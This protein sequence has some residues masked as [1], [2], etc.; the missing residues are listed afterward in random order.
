VTTNPIQ[1]TGDGYALALLAGSSLMD[2]EQVQF[3]P[4]SIIH[5]QNAAGF[6]LSCYPVSKLFNVNQERFMAKYNAENLENVTRDQ[7]S[8]AIANEICEGRGTPNGGV[9]LDARDQWDY[10]QKWFH[11]EADF[12]LKMGIDLRSDLPEIAPAAHFSMGGA[13]TAPNGM[14]EIGQLYMVGETAGGLHGANRLGNNALPECIVFG[15]R[16]GKLAAE[17]AIHTREYNDVSWTELQG[18]IV[19]Y[20]KAIL[21]SGKYRPYK[22][23]EQIRRLMTEN[24]GV[25]RSGRGLEKA[26]K[27]L[28]NM[29][30]TLSELSVAKP[31]YSLS[32]DVL[33]FFEVEKPSV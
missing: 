2:M 18:V 28:S 8:Y 14:S 13:V 24:S 30:N 12:C 19:K 1:S 16:S 7:L 3:Y 29:L 33:D 22:F 17:F 27:E 21:S 26:E 20:Q 23:K 11:H 9:W 6:C 5:P 32:K 15:A 10:I 4:V 31:N 25:L